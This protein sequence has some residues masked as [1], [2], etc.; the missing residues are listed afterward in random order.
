MKL[1]QIVLCAAAIALP[2]S[3]HAASQKSNDRWF[4]VEIILF[5]QL[6]DKT[7]LKE[8]FPDTSE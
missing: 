7:Q 8:S 4:E 6:G 5:S 3:S 2:L 1:T